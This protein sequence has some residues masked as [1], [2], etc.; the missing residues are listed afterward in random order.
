[1]TE[2]ALIFVGGVL[3]SSHCLGMCGGFALTIGAGARGLRVNF[4]RQV[5]YSLGRIFT[6]SAAGA[7]AGYGGLR[8][9]HLAPTFVHAQAVLA[10]VAGVLLVAVG[11]KSAGL[12]PC[13]RMPWRRFAVVRRSSSPPCL[14]SGFFASYLRGPGLKN[15]FL[16]G[17]FTGF[18]PCG[19][20]YGFLALAVSTSDLW[21][22]L[23]RMAAFG[24]GTA[25]LMIA[26]GCGGSLLGL[27]ARS[28]ALRIA[29][30]CVVATGA[31]SIL[32]GAGFLDWSGPGT[33]GC[34]MCQ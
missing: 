25:P 3:G 26:T 23:L 9:A 34:P 1:M 6:Y 15:A 11:L 27:S 29:A 13:G 21:Q 28:T 14:A 17:I 7:A 31:I 24:C 20:V 5:V 2:L 18:L 16:S 4:V 8:L 12:L 10:I 22:G 32:R 30:V 33:A 19:L